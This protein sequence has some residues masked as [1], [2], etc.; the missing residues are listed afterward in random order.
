MK[1]SHLNKQAPWTAWVKQ[2][3]LKPHFVHT[4]LH[5][6][7]GTVRLLASHSPH[8]GL[9]VSPM[10]EKLRFTVVWWA[11]GGRRAR[12]ECFCITQGQRKEWGEGSVV[13]VIVVV[14]VALLHTA[15]NYGLLLASAVQHTLHPKCRRQRLVAHL[16]LFRTPAGEASLLHASW[17]SRC[18]QE[19]TGRWRIQ[20]GAQPPWP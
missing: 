14:V 12:V 10:L 3:T 13:V 2:A 9:V 1:A 4:H 16:R 8:W 6:L 7:V 5:R 17:R 20:A 18:R 19:D 15:A 11:K